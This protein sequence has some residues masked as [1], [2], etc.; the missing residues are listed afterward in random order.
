MPWHLSPGFDA[1]LI[2]T[3]LFYE[4]RFLKSSLVVRLRSPSREGLLKPGAE[5]WSIL[6]SRLFLASK[7]CFPPPSEGPNAVA[8][9]LLDQIDIGSMTFPKLFTVHFNWPVAKRN[10][11]K[12][13]T[14]SLKA[15]L[16][17]TPPPLPTRLGN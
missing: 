11:E 12:C 10:Q 4:D 16:F 7:E 14:S 1:V 9:R 15:T 5:N 3:W 17:S 2:F 6:G 8:R 13:S